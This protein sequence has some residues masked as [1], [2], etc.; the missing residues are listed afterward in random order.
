M[1]YYNRLKRINDYSV[2]GQIKKKFP[3]LKMTTLDIEKRLLEL[4]FEFYEDTKV[5]IPLSIRLTLILA[6]IL[7]PFLF[8]YMPINYIATGRWGFRA[9][10]LSNWFKML[11]F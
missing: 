9:E 7:I 11:G 3:E 1:S 10:W 2:A 5:K 4:D 8:I 6:L